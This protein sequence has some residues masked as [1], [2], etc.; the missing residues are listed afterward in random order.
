VH[1][2]GQD[3]CLKIDFGSANGVRELSCRQQDM[4][5]QFS[6]VGIPS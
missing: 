1:T 6:G 5:S 3:M 2:I 4:T